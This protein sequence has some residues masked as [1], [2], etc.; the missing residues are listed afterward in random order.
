MAV[1]SHQS[2]HRCEHVDRGWEVVDEFESND[3]VVGA[4]SIDVCSVRAM[5]GDSVVDTG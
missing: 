4:L 5:E 3:D 2:T 1:R